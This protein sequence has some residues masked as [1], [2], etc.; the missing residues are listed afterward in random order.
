[1]S[2]KKEVKVEA[3]DDDDDEN[4]ESEEGQDCEDGEDDAEEA[5]EEAPSTSRK[6]PSA[7]IKTKPST[8]RRVSFKSSGSGV[9]EA[10]VKQ[11][12]VKAEEDAAAEA[13]RHAAKAEQAAKAMRH[14]AHASNDTSGKLQEPFDPYDKDPPTVK[15]EK[16]GAGA[17]PV[18]AKREMRGRVAKSAANILC[19][20][21]QAKR[22]AKQE[23]MCASLPEPT[24][25]C[26]LPD[27]PMG[28]DEF[29]ECALKQLSAQ[30]SD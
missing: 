12:R 6:R 26:E 14:F 3:E 23:R 4:D 30:D 7:F 19:D 2:R 8:K 17:G 18:V 20:V 5:R 11:D 24:S 15:A 1:L 21:R 13:E 25:N 27:V 28:Y 9:A 29:E 16:A 22:K 10:T